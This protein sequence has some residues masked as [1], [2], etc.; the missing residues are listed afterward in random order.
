MIHFW[1]IANTLLIFLYLCL[2]FS[3]KIVA[4]EQ[5]ASLVKAFLLALIL[6]FSFPVLSDFF[7]KEKAV[8]MEVK[9]FSEDTEAFAGS[10]IKTS[11]KPIVA[12]TEITSEALVFDLNELKLV[13]FALCSLFGIY[14]LFKN[15]LSIVRLEKHN[16]LFRKSLRTKIFVNPKIHSPMSYRFL[17][18]HILIPTEFLSKESDLKL[19]LRHEA[20]HIR[21]GDLVLNWFWQ[22]LGVFFTF[23][24]FFHLWKREWDLVTEIRCDELVLKNQY[25]QRSAYA[26]LLVRTARMQQTHYKVSLAMALDANLTRRI[27]VITTM[28]KQRGGL[29]RLGT[30]LAL[31]LI[32]CMGVIHATNDNFQIRKLK[33]NELKSMVSEMKSDIP[34]PVNPQ[35]LKWVNHYIATPGGRD[36]LIA[37]KA[38][39]AKIQERLDRVIKANDMPKDLVGVAFIESNFF[40]GF[41]STQKAKGIWQF[42]PSTAKRYGL[43]VNDR[44]DE[45][46]DLEKAT[47]AAMDYYKRL[48]SVTDLEKDWNLALIAYNSGEKRLIDSLNSNGSKDP[49]DHQVGD[50]EY[51]AKV[52]AGIIVMNLPNDMLVMH[53]L[54]KARVTS[55]FGNRKGPFQKQH[56]HKGLDLATREGTLIRSPLPGMVKEVTDLY[57]NT[58]AY[59][60]ALVIDHG[61]ELETRYFHL[62]DQLVKVGD[63]VVAG[64]N[65]AEVGSTGRSTG[66][67]LH[68]EF[69]HEGNLINPQSFL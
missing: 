29:L 41:T 6:S 51:L 69:H 63:K 43:V 68:I 21:Q 56:F 14:Q 60:K 38:R 23:N 30:V 13:L 64:Q 15:I 66:P 16:L 12:K 58:P 26:K 59:G 28:K 11:L 1:L 17:K 44:H 31:S 40:N 9:K 55:V 47:Q 5:H 48:L 19:A 2:H 8:F 24:P 42:I 49:F 3:K 67:H 25:L 36:T 46:L 57:K 52:I 32:T 18:N 35:V 54:P 22:I 20:T 27:E 37:G 62:K 33:L 53:P 10:S 45:R 4:K 50:N 61:N 7:P 34:L 65:I 39:Y